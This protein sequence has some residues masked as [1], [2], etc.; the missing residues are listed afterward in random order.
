[1]TIKESTISVLLIMLLMLLAACIN[2]N[3]EIPIIK[4]DAFEV[5]DISQV[6]SF[7]L[8]AVETFNHMIAGLAITVFTE[9][10][11]KYELKHGYADITEGLAIDS[12][13][14]FE[15]GS[16]AKL[17][18][19]VSVM[20]LYE[21]G[22]LDLHAN[23]FNYIPQEFF[24]DIIYTTTMHHLINHTAG[25]END[26]WLRYREQ[27]NDFVPAGEPVP[28][29]ENKLKDIFAS[30]FTTQ[31][32]QPGEVVRYSNE[33]IALAGHIIAQVSGLPFY[34]YVHNNIFVPLGMTRTALLPD[35]SD[36]DWVSTQRDKIRTYEIRRKQSVQRW[37]DSIYPAGSATGTIS[38]MIKFAR[39]LIPDEDG[40][41]ML[42]ERHETFSKLFPSL[43]GIQNIPVCVLTGFR[44][45]NGLIVYPLGGK[46]YRVLGHAG[47]TK[48]F[49]SQLV[50]DV[51]RGIGMVI[52][53]NNTRGVMSISVFFEGLAE[54]VFE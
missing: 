33:G 7:I 34:E 48:G 46:S 50:I 36:N 29:L 32:S 8:S 39:A 38:D 18:V 12:F 24:P 27:F 2:N 4:E 35:L 5:E 10:E 23:I 15:W 3:G 53:E 6:E 17:L 43:E 20:Q 51:D 30:G 28:N 52:C 14:V 1:M 31:S 25:F 41:S 16:I 19:Y 37:Q 26:Y 45:F 42:F 44:F 9:E 54:V 11:I 47:G 22:Q 40:A 21:R 49:R 13:S